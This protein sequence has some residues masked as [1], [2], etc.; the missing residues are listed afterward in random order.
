MIRHRFCSQ[1]LVRTEGK[2]GQYTCRARNDLGVLEKNMFLY[3]GQKPATPVLEAEV[4]AFDGARI[5]V[6]ELRD[7]TTRD[8]ASE[9]GKKGKALPIIG[10][11]V[12][13]KMM[14]RSDW[15]MANASKSEGGRG[16]TN[17]LLNVASFTF[18][19]TP[20]CPVHIVTQN[21]SFV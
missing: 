15:K 16:H 18:N 19:V 14:T 2:F 11:V 17:T 5:R 12:Q 7:P 10:Y 13:Y 21:L 3:K 4:V 20:F 1:V 8:P 9:E 6:K